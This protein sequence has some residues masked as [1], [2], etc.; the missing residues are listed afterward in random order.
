MSGVATAQLDGAWLTIGLVVG[1]VAF[2]LLAVRPF[3]RWLADREERSSAP[4]SITTLAIVF[5]MLLL[6]SSSK[7]IAL[8]RKDFIAA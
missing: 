2:V 3:A 7:M 8:V 5:G 1:Y 6:G 4:V